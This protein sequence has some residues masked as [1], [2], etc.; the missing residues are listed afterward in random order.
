MNLLGCKLDCRNTGVGRTLVQQWNYVKAILRAILRALIPIAR[1][2]CRIFGGMQL[3]P[4][5]HSSTAKILP[6]KAVCLLEMQLSA[7]RHDW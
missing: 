3:G 6:N 2:V 4:S 1:S 7:K 5:E